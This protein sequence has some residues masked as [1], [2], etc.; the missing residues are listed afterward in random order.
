LQQQYQLEWRDICAAP[1]GVPVT[2]GGLYRVGG[3]GLRGS[4]PFTLP[5]STGDV[6]VNARMTKKSTHVVGIIMTIAGGVG[7]G[8]GALALA[9][10]ANGSSGSDLGN[11]SERDGVGYAIAGAVLMAIGIT[12]AA[13]NTN[14]DVH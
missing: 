5:R 1:C 9:G 10:A 6:V 2:P 13:A 4:E 11:I 12:M 7:L 14:V 3:G 8:L